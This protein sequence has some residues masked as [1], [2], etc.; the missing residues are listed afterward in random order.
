MSRI[1]ETKTF[2]PV[3]IAVLTVSDT[4]G[5]DDDRSG[6]TLVDR[7]EAAGHIVAD[8]GSCPTSASR[9][10]RSS[11]LDARSDNRRGDLDRRHR[12]DGPRRDG[13]GASRRLREGDRRLRHGLHDGLD[14]EDRHLGGAKPR[15]RWGGKRHVSLSR[16]RA[17]PAPA[18]TPGTK[19][20]RSSSTIAI[21]PA[22]SSKSCRGSTNT[23]DG[24]RP[25]AECCG[26]DRADRLGGTAPEY[27]LTV[28]I[29][30]AGDARA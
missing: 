28:S 4:R 18:R 2:L 22:T 3:R 14:A 13:R 10:R 11:G 26:P 27:Y 8:R 1:D 25:L 19:S 24:N 16:C 17:A 6:Q 23:C 30:V 9:S 29:S 15:H 12:A 7:I 20:S 5:P 21:A